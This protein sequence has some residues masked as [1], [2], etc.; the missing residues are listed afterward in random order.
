MQ[1]L[2]RTELS[3]WT[4]LSAANAAKE[5]ST[6]PKIS[7]P[8][9][10]DSSW[11]RAVVPGSVLASL[12]DAG[13]YPDPWFGD[14]SKK[15]PDISVTGRDT[16]TYWFRSRFGLPTLGPAQRVWLELRGVNYGATVFVNGSAVT[17]SGPVKG[18]FL[19]H[20]FDIT[21]RP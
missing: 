8:G 14:N 9:F 11:L 18:M 1:S 3:K 21:N 2:N 12:V 10:D 19:R 17:P 20:R 15:I 16:Y 7:Q 13:V 6:G 5:G 4:T